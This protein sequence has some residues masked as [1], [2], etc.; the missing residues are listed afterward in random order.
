M[1][2]T[3]IIAGSANSSDAQIR[4]IKWMM[5]ATVVGGLA[6][7]VLSI[8]LVIKSHPAWAG[9]IGV[10]PLALLVGLMVWCE[11]SR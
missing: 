3:L 10:S 6:C 4:L 5:L 11:I 1:L 7:V 2:F 9:V 8:L